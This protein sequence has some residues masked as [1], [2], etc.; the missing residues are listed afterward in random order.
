MWQNSLDGC[1]AYLKEL[2]RVH[3][4]AKRDLKDKIIQRDTME[5]KKP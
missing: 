1:F 5:I 4:G 2:T 3:L